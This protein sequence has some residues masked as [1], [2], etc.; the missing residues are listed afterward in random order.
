MGDVYTLLSLWSAELSK[1]FKESMIFQNI[2][3]D[4]FRVQD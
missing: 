1:A 4:A 3:S 2:C